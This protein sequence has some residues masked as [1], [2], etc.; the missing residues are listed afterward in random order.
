VI[1]GILAG[2]AAVLMAVAA[3]GCGASSDAS[4]KGMRVGVAYQ[5]GGVTNDP[6][7]LLTHNGLV[8]AAAQAPGRIS[9]F[10]ELEAGTYD[11]DRDRYDRLALL[12][13]SGYNPVLAVGQ[14]YAGPDPAAG[15]LARA[16][17][18]CPGTHFVAVADSSVSA[19]NV[20]ALAFADADGAYLMGVAAALSTHTGVVGFLGG[21]RIPSVTT[22]EAGYRAGVQAT[23]PGTPVRSA[24]LATDPARCG[25]GNGVGEVSQDVA[26]QLY[27]GGADVVFQVAGAAG[28]GVLAAARIHG[29]LV[30]NS[31]LDP[32]QQ[33]RPGQ[34]LAPGE[35]A[36][37]LTALVEQVDLAVAGTLGDALAGRFSPGV[38]RFDLA[39]GRVGF[40]TSGTLVDPFVPRM[41]ADKAKIINGTI[42]VPNAL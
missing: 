13:Q 26:G 38:R 15:P 37:L 10:R 19:P 41:D 14:E 4:A 17:Q 32:Y 20:A 9:E 16:A 25:P 30:I 21:C 23:R 31:Y 5:V 36:A 7:N 40:A 22:F 3:G 35:K 28:S 11:T 27:G 18:T 34:E 42:V 8:R 29:G 24:Y 33:L 12:C 6:V 2:S 1:R 39:S